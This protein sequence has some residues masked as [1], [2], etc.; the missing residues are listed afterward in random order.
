MNIWHFWLFTA[1]GAGLWCGFLTTVGYFFGAYQAQ[2]IS[3]LNQITNLTIILIIGTAIYL[4]VKH[5][6]R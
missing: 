5:V 1:L 6:R 2:I 3:F 4:I